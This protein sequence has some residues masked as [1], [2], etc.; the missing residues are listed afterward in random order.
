M[1]FFML[2]TLL[3]RH[4]GPILALVFFLSHP[5]QAQE[6]QQSPIELIDY[7]KILEDRFEVKFSYIDQ[8]LEGLHLRPFN[9][10]MAL[11]E[12]LGELEILF[13]IKTEKLSDRYYALSRDGTVELC[14]RVL[15]NFARNSIPGATVEVMATGS[16]QITDWTGAFKLEQVPR[17]AL[18]KIRY[19]GYLTKYLQAGELLGKGHCPDILL[20]QHYEKLEEVTVYKF[21]TTGITKATDASIH[22]DIPGFGI[23]PGLIEP[24]VLQSVQAL[25]GIKSIDETVSDINIRGGTNDQNLILWN[26]IKMYQSGH[27]FG[28]ISAFNP[29]LTEKVTV[30]KNGTPA[31]FGDGVSGVIQMRTNDHLPET[32]TA[33]AGFN[34][35][36]GDVYAEIPMSEKWGLQVSA[37]RSMTDFLKTPT[38]K[39]FYRRAFQDSEFTDGDNNTLENGISREEDFYFYDFA[40]KLLVDFHEA[41][42]LRFSFINIRNDLSYLERPMEDGNPSTSLL[43]QDDLSLG[44]QL[45]SQWTSKFSTHLDLYYSSY[46]LEAQNIFGNG[47]QALFQNNSVRENALKLDT[48]YKL[49]DQ[50]FW[51]NGFQFIETGI[52]NITRLNQPEFNSEIKGVIRIFAPYTQLDYSARGQTFL[53][54]IGARVNYISNTNHFSMV[55]VEPRINL[56]LRLARFLRAELLGESKSQ[57]TNQVIDLEQNFLGIEKRRWV[58]SDENNLP[59]T[60]SRQASLGLNYERNDLYIG[61]EAFYKKVEGI[62]TATQ[63]FQNPHQFSGEIGSYQ[64]RGVEL[65]VNKKMD[66]IS[67]SLSYSFNKSDYLFDSIM[68]SKFPNNLDIRHTLTFAGTYSHGNLKLGLGLNFRTG[69]P[70][71]RP[72]EGADALDPSFFPARINYASPNGSRLPEYFRADASVIYAFGLGPGLR[73][74]AGF[75]ILNLTDR[76]NR[77]NRYYRVNGDGELETVDNLS[78]GLTPNLSFRVAF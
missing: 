27:F 17:E 72:L 12:I 14:G 55:L 76:R 74:D 6:R 36:S 20:A 69:K 11:G 45:H 54:K 56:N 10:S 15:D 48:G 37:R 64:I 60:K 75:S 59:V 18:I 43:Q 2:G 21:L 39:Q 22:L 33:G 41:H 66:N 63:G 35:I 68:P 42:K 73:A 9:G 49:N 65:L 57:T 71:T 13:Q 25:P 8:D 53:A 31:A 44:V 24:D 3:N 19:L 38:Y 28:L 62:S 34:L 77:L 46:D 16:V 4:L 58:L 5:L 50:L 78:L 23:L 30:F 40:G 52:T 29:Y 26:G 61:A 51:E 32:T 1:Y 70:Y 47:A 67:G 7:L